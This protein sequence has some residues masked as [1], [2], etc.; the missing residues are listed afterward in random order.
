MSG[1]FELM[2]I[3]IEGA[4]RNNLRDFERGAKMKEFVDMCSE[5]SNLIARHRGNARLQ[6]ADDSNSEMALLKLDLHIM[7]I[8]INELDR[9]NSEE[10]DQVEDLTDAPS[11]PTRLAVTMPDGTVIKHQYASDTF[12]EVIDEL[13]RRKVK[14]LDLKV[15]G[16]DLMST[17]EDDQQRRKLGGY[18]IN[19]GTP[20]ER[21]KRLLEDIA[22][23]LNVRLKVEIIPK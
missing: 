21:K 19:V 9:L 14:K 10:L 23:G 3:Q 2:T 16:T 5:L 17:S 6:K 1:I 20:T 12:V 15:N 13:G 18:Y 4:S 11:P 7:K 8:V 22:S